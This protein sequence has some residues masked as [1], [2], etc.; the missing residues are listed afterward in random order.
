MQQMTYAAD[1]DKADLVASI[2]RAYDR[3]AAG[4]AEGVLSHMADNVHF[5][6]SG[7]VGGQALVPPIDGK[8]G[9]KTYYS[10]FLMRWDLSQMRVDKIIVDENVAAIE[11]VG[12]MRHIASGQAF[13]TRCCD[14]L[15][16][17]DGLIVKV[18]CYSDTFSV[19]RVAGLFL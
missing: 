18:R 5:W 6:V 1:R 19:I 4:D 2:R 10:G 11:T 8:D 3:R 14:I 16:F 7:S 15:E 12:T 13:E 17:R 9:V